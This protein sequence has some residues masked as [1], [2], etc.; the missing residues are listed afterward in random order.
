M[1]ISFPTTGLTPNVTT[2]TYSSRTW[3]W[4]GTVWQSVG[5]V[6]GGITSGA[7][8]TTNPSYYVVIDALV[9]ATQP[10]VTNGNFLQF[11]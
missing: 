10:V 11:C 9:S 6:T 7:Y 8:S 1:A 2:Y 4:T 3:I 5:T